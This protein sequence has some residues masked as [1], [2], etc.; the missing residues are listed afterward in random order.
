MSHTTLCTVRGQRSGL[1]SYSG[2]CSRSF[3]SHDVLEV[4]D[5]EA[6]E[7]GSINKQLMSLGTP[8]SLLVPKL[9]PVSAILYSYVVFTQLL[10]YSRASARRKGFCQLD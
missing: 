6:L 1:T 4:L 5:K 2:I 8:I 10:V 3:P 7:K 9:P